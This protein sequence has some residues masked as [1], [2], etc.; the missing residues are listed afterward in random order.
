MNDIT[1][2]SLE[3]GVRFFDCIGCRIYRLIGFDK[4]NIWAYMDDKVVGLYKESNRYFKIF[5]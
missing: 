5:E 4:E 1:M 2:I 3:L